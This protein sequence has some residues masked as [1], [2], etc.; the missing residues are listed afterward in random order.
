[1]VLDRIQYDKV[2]KEIISDKTKFKELP[3]D[4]TIKREA[5]LQRYLRTLKNEKKC[6]N[7]VDNYKFIYPSGSA[8]AKI[9]GTPKMYKLTDSDSFPKLRPTVSSVGT[10]NYNL[11]KYLCNLLSPHLSEQYC[12][13]DTFT[14]VEQLKG[15]SLVDKFLV[16][17]DVTSLFTN[18]PLSE[19]IKL[20]VDL[21]KTSLNISE[22]DLTCLFNFATC[23]THFLFKGKFYDQID[24]VA[25]RS[26]LA[27]VLAN[28]LMGHYEKEWLS[29]YDGVSPS[30]YT[31]YVDDIFSVF[32]SRDEAKR[33]FSYLNSRYPNV[34]FTMEIEV[35]NVSPFLDVLIDNRSNMLN[36]TTYHKSTYSGLLLNFDSFTSRFYKISLI[37]CLIDRA[38]RVNN[39]WASFHNHV[40]KIKETLKRN[41]FPPSLIDK[42][43]KSCLNKVHSNSDR[44]NPESDKF[45]TLENTQNNSEKVVKNL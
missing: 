1:M 3:E 7:D 12:T 10:Y 23:E 28:L 9:Y 8:P 34:K 41:S 13:K 25:M 45:R 42:I 30:Y 22:K 31:R 17:F 20:A 11:A 26:L 33:F 15:V 6:L 24:G 18:I 40:T 38:Y 35:N 39:K 29:N 32:N 44:S 21:I 27:P 43:T 2:I 4:V 36:T 19:T 37:K 5:K 14:F 16:S